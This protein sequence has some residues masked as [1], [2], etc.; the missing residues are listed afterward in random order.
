VV[1]ESRAGGGRS[2]RGG[3]WTAAGRPR[4]T[5]RSSFAC[6]SGRAGQGRQPRGVL[7]LGSGTGRHASCVQHAML[8]RDSGPLLLGAGAG[9]SG[10]FRQGPPGPDPA[11]CRPR[12]IIRPEWQPWGGVVWWPHH[13]LSSSH[14]ACTMD[15]RE[16]TDWPGRTDWP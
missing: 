5:V 8:G 14:G 13:C 12:N 15:R 7:I 9:A 3:G 2:R 6:G 16:M 10:T 1:D 11:A 4:G